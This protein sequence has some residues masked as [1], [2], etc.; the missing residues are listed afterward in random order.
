MPFYEKGNVRIR[1]EE[2]GSGFP[3]LVTPGGGLNSRVSNWQTAVINAMAIVLLVPISAGLDL[4]TSG[5]G[6]LSSA[7]LVDA[8][9]ADM[10][11]AP[12]DLA[13]QPVV[14]RRIVL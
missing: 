6:R 2:A 8:G 14:E 3:L 9:A 13:L 1:Y 11:K 10:V 7:E 12:V 5:D 4:P